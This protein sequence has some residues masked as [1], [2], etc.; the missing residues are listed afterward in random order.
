MAQK[1]NEWQQPNYAKQNPV[2]RNPAKRVNSYARLKS[3]LSLIL[4]VALVGFIGA[5]ILNLTVVKAAEI[6]K[7][8]K[9]ITALEARNDLLLVKVD[10]LRSVGHIESTA[11]A[12]GMEKPRGK[13]Y[14]SGNITAANEE[15]GVPAFQQTA[16]PVSD[17]KFDD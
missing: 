7:L 15:M 3:V 4:L 12:M 13:V 1:K 11:L 17:I 8:Q 9:E 2:K 5:E 6:H 16:T 10:Q 14:I